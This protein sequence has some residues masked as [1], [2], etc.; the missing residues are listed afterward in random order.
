[1]IMIIIIIIIIVIM[2]I[3]KAIASDG[4]AHQSPAPREAP[5]SA[6]A[7]EAPWPRPPVDGLAASDGCADDDQPPY[8]IS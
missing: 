2:I 3:M 8:I 4:C 5:P 7:A 1:M 6:E